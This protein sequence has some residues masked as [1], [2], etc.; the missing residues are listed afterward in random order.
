MK[1]MNISQRS[2]AVI[3]VCGLAVAGVTSKQV[4]AQSGGPLAASIQPFMDDHTIAGALLVVADKNG[5]LDEETVGYADPFTKR[6]MTKDTL[7][8]IASMTKTFTA[9]AVMMLQDQRKLSVDDPISKYLPEFASEQVGV[10]AADGTVTLRAP[11][12]PMLIRHLLSHMSGFTGKPNSDERSPLD[13]QSKELAAQALPFDPGTHYEYCNKNFAVLGRLIEVVSGKPYAQFI[14]DNITVPLGMTDSTFWP[15]AE[16]LGRL[17]KGYGSLDHDP[18]FTPRDIFRFDPNGT[19]MV[20]W[21]WG[22]LV[23]SAAD[24]TRY[25][26]MFLNGGILDGKRILSESAVRQMTST[27]TAHFID[28]NGENGYGFG[29]STARLDHNEPGVISPGDFGHGGA[30]ST[31]MRVFPRQNLIAIILMQNA[32][33]LKGKDRGLMINPFDQA[34]LKQY[35][36]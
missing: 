11:A 1:R 29:M 24:L 5:I 10:T 4:L 34:V 14:Y 6:P 21:P 12:S 28:K 23:S 8:C 32:G 18:W 9:V 19:P 26:R 3:L 30:W 22:S 2:L 7:F 31:D 20:P 35:G 15:N 33:Y 16:Q 27:Q 25:C 13:H 36:H 17:V